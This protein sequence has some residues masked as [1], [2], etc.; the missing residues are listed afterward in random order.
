MNIGDIKRALEPVWAR[1]RLLVGRAVLAAV[2]E[3][4]GRRWATG[5]LLAGELIEGMEFWQHFG[6]AS[7]PQPG[8]EALVVFMAGDRSHG[9]VISTDDPR[10][11]PLG[12]EPGEV[13]LYSSGDVLADDEEYP[14]APELAPE[15]WPAPPEGDGPP[16]PLCR[17]RLTP[18]RRIEIVCDGYDVF[19]LGNI[20]LASATGLE[21]LAPQISAGPFG[22]ATTFWGEDGQ[23]IARVGD[24]VA[25]D[26]GSSE[27]LHPIIGEGDCHD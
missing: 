6:M 27:G 24:C 4:G 13:A 5:G 23:R 17:L 11:R 3:D 14:E 7:N 12:L 18:D 16:A 21:L 25:V 20:R 22:A 10:F 19:S 8:C 15:G 1:L 26:H 9:H 2:T